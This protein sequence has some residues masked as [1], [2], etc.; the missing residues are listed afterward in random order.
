MHIVLDDCGVV[1]GRLAL[2]VSAML[3]GRHVGVVCTLSLM[4]AVCFVNGWICLVGCITWTT[5]GCYVHTVLDDRCIACGRL[6]L[7]VSVMLP[8]RQVVV[9]CTLSLT[10]AV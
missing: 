1:C 5:G 6:E 9:V 2:T 8:G 7:T 10:V 4:V 3:P